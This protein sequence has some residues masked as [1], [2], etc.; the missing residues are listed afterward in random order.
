VQASTQRSPFELLYGARPRLP[1]DVALDP[2]APPRVPAAVERAERMQQ[3]LSFVK[4]RLGEAQQRQIDNA[5]RREA[6]FVVGD[7]VLLSTEGLRLRGFDNKLCSRYIGPF[8]VTA[9]INPNAYELKL[10]PQLQALHP[11][12]N[13]SRLKPYRDGL[14]SFPTRPVRYA[15]PPPV[16]EA[17]SNGQAEYEVERLLA[18]RR[19]GRATEYLVQ[20]KGYPPEENTWERVRNLQGARK[21]VSEFE[22]Q[23]SE[24]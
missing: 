19:V 18:R 4:A 16:A 22:S 24:D 12:F 11:V 5:S 10:P 15:R 8:A 23:A 21:L 13:I 9:V 3:A 6:F 17:D 14:V 7:Q 1:L 2:L 20:W